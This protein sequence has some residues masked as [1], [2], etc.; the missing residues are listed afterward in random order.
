MPAFANVLPTEA[1]T[2]MGNPEISLPNLVIV[3]YQAP[4]G[5]QN[6]PGIRHMQGSLPTALGS[7]MH[8]QTDSLK[9]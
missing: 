4:A 1:G 5:H 6:N 3:V 7:H 2:H 9:K 8:E